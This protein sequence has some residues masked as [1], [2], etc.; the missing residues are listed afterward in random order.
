MKK[1]IYTA[2]MDW[3][4]IFPQNTYFESLTLGVAEFGDG[5]LRNSLRLNEVIRVGLAHGLI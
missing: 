5:H 3:M 1:L 2:V 4:F